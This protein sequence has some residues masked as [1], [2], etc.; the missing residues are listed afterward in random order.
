MIQLAIRLL[1]LSFY[2][3]QRKTL[4]P[5]Y[6]IQ[7][8]EMIVPFPDAAISSFSQ[9][10]DKERWYILDELEQGHTYEARVSYA[11]SVR[12]ICLALFIGVQYKLLTISVVSNRVCYGDIRHGRNSSYPKRTRRTGGTSRCKYGWLNYLASI[13]HYQLIML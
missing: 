8:Y 11:A 4:R 9:S 12:Y 2:T 1:I 5:P 6:A 3:K 7:R 10:E 13:F